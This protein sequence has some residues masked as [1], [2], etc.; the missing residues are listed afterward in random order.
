[1]SRYGG[2]AL[3]CARG[4]ADAYGPAV[5]A[6]LAREGGSTWQG[7]ASGGGGAQTGSRGPASA[8]VQQRTVARR[9]WA[10]R[11]AEAR[12]GTTSRFDV[13]SILTATV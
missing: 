4:R 8:C 7:G 2:R 11:S 3:A 12:R 1:M 10:R 9:A 13:V 5:T 6:V